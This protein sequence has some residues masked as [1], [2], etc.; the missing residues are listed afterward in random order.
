MAL[1]QFGKL[2]NEIM[3]LLVNYEGKSYYDKCF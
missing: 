3:V 2:P 1:A